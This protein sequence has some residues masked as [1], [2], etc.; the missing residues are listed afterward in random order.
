MAC[1]IVLPVLTVLVIVPPIWLLFGIGTKGMEL[2]PRWR[3]FGILG[4]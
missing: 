1:W 4:Y 2:G 3:V